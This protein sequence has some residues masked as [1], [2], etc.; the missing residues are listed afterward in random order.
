MDEIGTG[1]T[2]VF[3]FLQ[4]S[5]QKFEFKV[6][7]PNPSTTVDG[8][9]K[10]TGR[11]LMDV[12]YSHTKVPVERQKIVV[13]KTKSNSGR[14]IKWWKG[15]LWEDFDF[16]SVLSQDATG[17]GEPIEL[18]ATLMGTAE[19]LAPNHKKTIFV[20]D[21]T[22]SEKKVAEEREMKKSMANVAAMI[23]AL[24]IPPSYRQ[25]PTD[26][27]SINSDYDEDRA[28]DRLVHGFP[29]LRIDALLRHQQ[30][31]KNQSLREDAY[32]PPPQ[33]LGRVVMTLGLEIQRAY[34]NDLAVLSRD[35][36]LVSGLDDGHIHMWK[37]CQKAK[38]FV[39]QSA[40]GIGIFDAFAGVDSVLALDS[41]KGD[42]PAA[43]ATAGRGC[44]RI[45][46]SEGESLLGRSSPLP[47]T[48]P[49]GLIR[50]PIGHKADKD[51]NNILCLAARF[52]VAPPP[53]RRPRL[54][55][56]DSVGRRRVEQIQ[57]TESLVV[58]DLTKLSK[59]A[60]ILYVDNVNHSESTT[61]SAHNEA[62]GSN[63]GKAE[64]TLRSLLVNSP[65]P[66]TCMESWKDGNKTYLVVGDNLGGVMFWKIAM[67]TPPLAAA[68]S[69]GSHP[70]SMLHASPPTT[71]DPRNDNSNSNNNDDSNAPRLTCTKLRYLKIASLEDPT[72]T[73]SAIACLKYLSVT[74]QLC[75]S[76]KEIP[77]TNIALMSIGDSR[78]EDVSTTCFPIKPAQAVHCISVDNIIN[79]SHIDPLDFT[80]DGHKD[81][82]QHIL[83]LPNGDIVTAGGKHDATTKVWS[84]ARIRAA[85][86][87][88][89][90]QGDT[91]SIVSFLDASPPPILK[92]ASSNNLAGYVFGMALLEDFKGRSSDDIESKGSKSQFDCNPFAIAVAQYNVVKIV[93]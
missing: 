51:N 44:I 33:L 80:L 68:S 86:G 77:P 12:V 18:S 17:T 24:Q 65:N 46:D 58:E 85:T 9:A 19:V 93:I 22:P 13:S 64:P 4:W 41:S 27:G 90:E 63:T 47:F 87:E 76:T 62:F 20:E 21:M 23:P 43:F 38:D 49:T 42:S 5:K 30:N 92:N 79:K 29:Q 54:V 6:A 52:R 2:S 32:P 16:S 61:S 34:V 60:Q 57:N 55:P 69:R 37:H 53:S 10:F 14:K 1:S 74:K 31:P 81:V 40:G 84:W 71:V 15:V 35:G 25:L 75:V 82:V 66:I 70:A 11:S 36:T 89:T 45:W 28:Y 91:T 83:S 39:H 8:S 56:Q 26:A 3:V 78:S 67:A 73:R 7:V 48:S 50:I 59:S 72:E 88:H